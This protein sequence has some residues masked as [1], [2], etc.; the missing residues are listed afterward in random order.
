VIQA[1]D[2]RAV[3]QQSFILHCG[4]PKLD[5][6]VVANAF[7]AD[8]GTEL[9]ENFVVGLVYDFGDSC[10]LG[11]VSGVFGGAL[12]MNP[13]VRRSLARAQRLSRFYSRPSV[14]FATWS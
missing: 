11:G 8:S 5:V 12:L 13:T 2:L 6:L 1:S 14:H 4:S 3:I 7:Y 10:D 9:C